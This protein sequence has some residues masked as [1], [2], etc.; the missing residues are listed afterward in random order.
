VSLD[1]SFPQPAARA[2]SGFDTCHPA[3]IALVII[4]KKVQQPV[5]R[6]NPKLRL[7]RVARLPGLPAGDAGRNYD[8]AE[9]AGILGGKRKDVRYTEFA[10]VTVIQRPDAGV[11]DDG[12]SD[13]SAGTSRRHGRQPFTQAGRA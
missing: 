9:V 7:D 3:V 11:R 13:G 2:Q 6:Q 10:P 1:Q 12:D 5:Q 4:A 8:I